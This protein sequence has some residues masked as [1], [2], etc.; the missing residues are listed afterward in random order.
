VFCDI[1]PETFCVTPETVRAAL[2][3]KTKAVM[4]VHLFGTSPGGGDR[5]ARRSVLED[6]AQALGST[7]PQGRPGSIGTA[8]TFS[9]YPSKNLGAFGDGGAITTSDPELAD[10]ARR[11]RFH[12]SRDKSP[13]R[14]WA[15]TRGSTRSRPRSCACSFPPRSLVR[16]AAGGGGPLSERRSGGPGVPPHVTDGAHP[17]WHLYVSG[18]PTPSRS[19]PRCRRRDRRQLVLPRAHATSSRGC[20]STPPTTSCREPR[21]RRER[22][23]RSPSAGARRDAGRRGRRRDPQP[24]GR[25]PGR[26]GHLPGLSGGLASGWVRSERGFARPSGSAP[27]PAARRN[28]RT[29]A[30]TGARNPRPPLPPRAR[31]SGWRGLDRVGDGVGRWISRRRTLGPAPL[32]ADGVARV[33][34]HRGVGRNVMDH[35]AVGTDLRA[36]ADGDRPEQL[37][38]RA[39]GHVV[40]DG[41]VALAG[42][43]PVPPSVTP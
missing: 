34:H 28:G 35:H 38:A 3:V 36:V 8:A 21:S 13:S 22:T 29:S 27:A 9:F 25:E 5:G 30:R 16:R 24:S 32:D 37:R 10:R 1:D 7:G 6:A 14:R 11:L 43:K 26:R 40:L 31:R 12:G 41:G 19:R 39:D 4:V 42:G 23:S 17:A 15:T 2:T 18:R 20:A 33:P